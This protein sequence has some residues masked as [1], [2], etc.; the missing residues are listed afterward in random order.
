MIVLSAST[1]HT[2]QLVFQILGWGVVAVIG[3]TLLLMALEWV[4][5]VG[6]YIVKMPLRAIGSFVAPAAV[7]TLVGAA[8]TPNLHAVLIVA[9]VVGVLVFGFTAFITLE[10]M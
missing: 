9:A 7:V 6:V 8:L 5:G 1:Q 4:L 3:G 10:D 2:A